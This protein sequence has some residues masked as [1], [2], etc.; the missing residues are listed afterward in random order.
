MVY[1]FK[2]T[3]YPG[4]EFWPRYRIFIYNFLSDALLEKEIEYS[5]SDNQKE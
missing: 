4:R 5:N 1:K 3:I 2:H